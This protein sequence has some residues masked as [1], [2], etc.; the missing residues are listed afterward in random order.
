MRIS[1]S[2]DEHLIFAFINACSYL[3]VLFYF[4]LWGRRR[5][6]LRHH[7]FWQRLFYFNKNPKVCSF[8]VLC[9]QA[10]KRHASSPQMRVWHVF[11]CWEAYVSP[12]NSPQM[13]VWHVHK[14]TDL[15][16]ILSGSRNI[17]HVYANYPETWDCKFSICYPEKESVHS[18]CSTQKP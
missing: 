8:P 7:N 15:T 4:C 16:R 3:L 14:N 11:C 9:L 12:A 6:F 13:R 18:I 17:C 2:V 1:I 10:D 5:L